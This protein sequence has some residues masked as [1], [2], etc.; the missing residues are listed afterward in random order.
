[1]KRPLAL[2]ALYAA[3]V[4]PAMFSRDVWDPDEPRFAQIGR[5]MLRSGDWVIPR[6][7][8]EPLALLPPFHD[9]V[10]AAAGMPFGD[11]TPAASR[12][13]AALGGFLA[14]ASLWFLARRWWGESVATWSSIVLMTSVS[15][16]LQASYA[17]VDMLLVGFVTCSFVAFRVAWE[18]EDRGLKWF[19][20]GCALC[21]LGTLTKGPLALV[22]PG[23]VFLTLAIAERRRGFIRPLWMLAGLGV[24]LA[25]TAPWYILACRRGGPEF[26]HE[27]LV[28]HNFGMFFETWSHHQ[29][30]WYYLLNLPWTF[31]PWIVF[32]PAAFF[33]SRD[34][35]RPSASTLARAVFRPE[36]RDTEAD[37]H[38]FLWIWFLVLF[39]F[40]SIS[41]AK[42]T[43]YLLPVYPAMALLV[44][45]R[46][47]SQA[48][49]PRAATAILASVAAIALLAVGGLAL[50]GGAFIPARYKDEAAM[51]AWPAFISVL[52]LALWLPGFRGRSPGLVVGGMAAALFAV[53]LLVFPRVD[54]LKSAQPLCDRVRQRMG[55]RDEAGIYG[56][57]ERKIGAFRYY[58]DHPLATFEDK[59]EHPDPAALA[60]WWDRPGP[61]WL[62]VDTADTLPPGV[63]EQGEKVDEEEVGHRRIEVLKR[64]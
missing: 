6:M 11:V 20:G 53:S 41:Q 57:Q 43:K 47:S 2:L 26:T 33:A 23:L 29:P 15:F 48:G 17:Q 44:G 60:T 46:L 13:G 62:I 52:G 56:I 12:T 24:Y 19:L 51:L 3:L 61:L 7:N 1:V 14:L 37:R 59:E 16:W 40:F 35:L 58:L 4:V 32:L 42:Q 27:L 8:G 39:A 36:T 25:V 34:A 9:W 31:A 49:T 21:G 45:R 5:E 28:K 50:S 55:S 63:R 30:P 54:R 64:R 18:A 22:A 38:R 10:S